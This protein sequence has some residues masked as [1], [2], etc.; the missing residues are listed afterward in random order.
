MLS[1]EENGFGILALMIFFTFLGL[2]LSG[3]VDW[4]YWAV[5]APLWLLLA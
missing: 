3:A 4:S 1:D 2:K 5:T